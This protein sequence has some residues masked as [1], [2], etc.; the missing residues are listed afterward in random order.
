MQILPAKR[1]FSEID[2]LPA[3]TH[4]PAANSTKYPTPTIFNIEDINPLF[5]PVF[6][7]IVP[8]ASNTL[9]NGFKH[10]INII[11]EPT[12]DIN[13]ANSGLIGLIVT[14]AIRVKI[15]TPITLNR[16][17]NSISITQTLFLLFQTNL[18]PHQAQ[19]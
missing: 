3:S 16:S 18:Q 2:T 13:I 1:I 10:S 11:Q 5:S 19:A 6:I 9:F 4:N 8:M 7:T 14:N 15:P 12:M 17:K